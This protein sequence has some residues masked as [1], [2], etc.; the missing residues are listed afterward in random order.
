MTLGMVRLA[1]APKHAA[2][3]R[4]EAVPRCPGQ[5]R[6]QHQFR[7][8]LADRPL[9]DDC[10]VSNHAVTSAR[11]NERETRAHRRVPRGKHPA[12]PIQP[13]SMRLPQHIVP[14][15]FG[16]SKGFLC[17]RIWDAL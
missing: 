9:Y 12:L 17:G 10:P 4:R 1:F 5:V 7:T 13:G 16:S 6:C 14:G 3:G 2:R 15:E 8:S 11:A